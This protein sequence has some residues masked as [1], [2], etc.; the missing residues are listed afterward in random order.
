MTNSLLYKFGF[1]FPDG[2]AAKVVHGAH[3][4]LPGRG[5]QKKGLPLVDSPIYSSLTNQCTIRMSTPVIAVSGM[6]SSLRNRGPADLPILWSTS[7]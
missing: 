5:D 1:D 2:S 4:N 3:P 7:L 6:R